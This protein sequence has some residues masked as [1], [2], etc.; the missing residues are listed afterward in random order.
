[1]RIAILGA[2]G[3]I[4]K[5]LIIF[6]T[7]DPKYELYLFARNVN[8]VQE[9]L[10]IIGCESS[11]VLLKYDNFLVGDYDAVI[12]CIGIADPNKQKIAGVDLFRLTEYYDNLILDYLGKHKQTIYLNFS[13]GAEIGRASCRERV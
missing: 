4:A 2:T 10:R 1:M 3:H 8:I 11:P 7:K 13:S 9:F 12:N 5:N 6:F